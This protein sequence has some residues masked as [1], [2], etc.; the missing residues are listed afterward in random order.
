MK[1]NSKL[2]HWPKPAWRKSDSTTAHQR[3]KADL[4]RSHHWNAVPTMTRRKL[5][6]RH[7]PAWRPNAC[8]NLVQP[9]VSEVRFHIEHG[10]HI[11]VSTT[12]LRHRQPAPRVSHDFAGPPARGKLSPC[13]VWPRSAP[14]RQHGSLWV[15]QSQWCADTNVVSTASCAPPNSD[16]PSLP[17]FQPSGIMLT[18][19]WQIQV[20]E[21][22]RSSR[23]I[24]APL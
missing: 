22:K 10:R 9:D 19:C 15:W 24:R 5:V 14:R 13:D 21:Q 3:A 2:P 17:N 18:R 23:Q 4:R 12:V 11:V 6:L 8:A 1:V 16:R 7:T 20:L